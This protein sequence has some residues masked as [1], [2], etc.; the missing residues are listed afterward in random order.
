MKKAF[1]IDGGA[2]RVLCSIPAFE[3]FA[4]T[5][6]DFIIV[7]GGWPEC[8]AGNPLLHDKVFHIQHKD[9]FETHLK[10]RE[11]LTPEPYRL[12]DYFNQKCNLI[13][14]FD[15]I[16]NDLKVIPETKKITVELSKQEQIDGYT[17]VR[18]VKDVKKKDKVIVFQPFGS[19]VKQQGNFI[20]DPSGRSF[21]L[22]DIY[23]L[24]ESLTKNYA[25]ILM[26]QLT[27]PSNIDLGIAQPQ[28]MS[29]RTWMGVINAS[30]Y[31]LGCDSLGQHIAYSLDKPTT[32]VIG[33]TF[34]E[35]ISYPNIENFTIIDNG[36]DKRRYAP[37]RITMDEMADRNNE[38]L[39]VLPKEKISEIIESINSK[40]NITPSKVTKSLT[41]PKQK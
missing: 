14:A 19:G 34:P 35:N 5:E 20:F 3:N 25:V 13:Q 2:G 31:F 16:I 18:E 38:N 7:S 27:L 30:D 11:I 9:L 41:I 37:I 21:E 23:K 33:S 28:N 32:V 10:N 8:F 15:I 24:I 6:S 17:V 4:K 26:S 29:I 39:M 22:S 40:L 12:N 1:F 36:K